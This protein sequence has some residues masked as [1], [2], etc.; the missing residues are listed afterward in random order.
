MNA[1]P[2]IF[3]PDPRVADLSAYQ[4]LAYAG[5]AVACLAVL[6]TA[7]WLRPAAGGTA[8]HEQ[9]GLGACG[10]LRA[11]GYPCASC[12]MTTSFAHFA[13]GNVA[14]SLYVQPMGTLLATLTAAAVWV[15]LYGAATGLPVHTHLARLPLRRLGWWML[16]AF[17]LAWAWKIWLVRS[18]H[19][20]W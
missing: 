17:L 20:G 1:A 13:R 6:L 5:V 19:D 10:I 4:R 7:A 11:T 14:A 8:T 16:A 2:A 18:G 15:G 12:G 9:L 3:A